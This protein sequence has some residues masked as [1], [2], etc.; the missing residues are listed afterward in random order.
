VAGR[1]LALEPIAALSPH[2]MREDTAFT[3]AIHLDGDTLTLIQKSGPS[4][5]PPA[6]PITMKLTRVTD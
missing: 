3:E 2:M 4:G 5:R 6:Y 1:A